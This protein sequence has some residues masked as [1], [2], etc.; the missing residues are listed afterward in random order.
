MPRGS[1]GRE[2]LP[3][4]R[5]AAATP[6]ARDGANT[7]PVPVS[8]SGH[9]GAAGPADE[10][11]APVGPNEAAGLPSAGS[12]GTPR[13]ASLGWA[14][15]VRCPKAVS[16]QGPVASASMSVEGRVPMTPPA[17]ARRRTAK[18]SCSRSPG[19][20]STSSGPASV[21][22]GLGSTAERQ[23]ART[24]PSTGEHAGYPVGD[25]PLPEGDEETQE[26]LRAVPRSRKLFVGG[27]PQG[28]DRDG[29]AAFL[30]GFGAVERAWLQRHRRD[31]QRN[32]RGFGFVLFRDA[33]AVE[34]LLGGSFSRHLTLQDGTQIEVKAALD[35]PLETTAARPSPRTG[36]ATPPA[37]GLSSPRLASQADEEVKART[38][39]G[40]LEQPHADPTPAAST[41]APPQ[42]LQ[43]ACVGGPLL[44]LAGRRGPGGLAAPHAGTHAEAF[45][46]ALAAMLVQ[47]MPDHYEE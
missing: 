10:A 18:Q 1:P 26:T 15:P 34:Q 24:S 36:E 43:G 40:A 20:R 38:P 13:K 14:R 2:P 41:A 35:G 37:S 33:L 7:L 46:A 16:S 4:E 47:A 29:L 12:D 11:A 39:V 44:D 9:S 23:S 19:S 17:A 5:V 8:W 21:G 31:K 3:A 42:L 28:M 45:R 27:I 32:H 25:P 22:R 30:R 6:T